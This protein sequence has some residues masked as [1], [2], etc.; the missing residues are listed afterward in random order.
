MVAMSED[1]ADLDGHVR[2]DDWQQQLRELEALISFLPELFREDQISLA[3]AM[4]GSDP[5][6]DRAMIVLSERLSE[7]AM[8]HERK[9]RML[10]QAAISLGLHL[11]QASLD[12]ES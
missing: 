5:Q 2:P 1:H 12:R 3:R 11:R 9:A 10:H 4:M 8:W 7:M 6:A